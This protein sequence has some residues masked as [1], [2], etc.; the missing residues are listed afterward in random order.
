M[1]KA[2]AYMV[3]AQHEYNEVLQGFKESFAVTSAESNKVTLGSPLPYPGSARLQPKR[4]S[5]TTYQVDTF[6]TLRM[7]FLRRRKC[8]VW[9]KCKCHT[10]V[11]TS[12]SDKLQS[13]MG[14]LFIGYA[15]LPAL[16]P[17]CT[18]NNCQRS[19]EGFLQINYYFPWWFF[20]KILHIGLAFQQDSAIPRMSIHV[21]NVRDTYEDIF[22][23]ARFNDVDSVEYQ[24][25][26][27][28]ASVFDVTSDSGHSPLHVRI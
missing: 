14:E 27:G 28:R 12:T 19:S 18:E 7:R 1:D 17:A 8:D 23:S 11:R 16:T 24:L 9:C 22:I 13:V 3:A 15:G 2:F 26:M 6:S 20:A 4:S 21:L 10:Y 5:R 25:T